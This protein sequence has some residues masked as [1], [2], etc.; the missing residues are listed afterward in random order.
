MSSSEQ[1]KNKF[2]STL[3]SDLKNSQAYGSLRKDTKEISDFYLTDEQREQLKSMKAGKRSF[4]HFGW[5]MRAMFY[6]LT[7]V[8]RLMFII[9]ILFLIQ[10]QGSFGEVNM[11]NINGNAIVGGALLVLVIL[12]EL[13]DKL[14][15]HDELE[16]GRKIQES[17]MPERMPNVNGWKLWLFTRS[18]NEVCG[19]LI[20]FLKIDEHRFSVAIADV[21]GK[22]L[23][24]ALITAK[25]QATIR[26]LAG[27]ITSLPQLIGRINTIVHRDSPAHMFS[28]LLYAECS[29]LNET[30]RFVN[31]GHFPALVVRNSEIEECVRGEAALGL[32]T[33]MN[34]SEHSA[35]LNTND[36]FVLYSD[37]LTEAKNELGE[38][39]GKEQL[40]NLLK[41]T[42]NESPEQTGFAILRTVDKFIG[43]TTPSDDLSI[44]ILQRT[45]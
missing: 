16:A 26:S 11:L 1:P 36:R 21:A 38:F 20:D 42:L 12:L 33:I 25:L 15:A 10:V 7:P 34:F 23:H 37:G 35:M 31:A 43:T 32:T 6:K 27:E 40:L 18:A 14:L 41:S 29:E 5:I 19:D 22:G 28:S 9:G 45:E 44:I 30:I 24:A 3:R 8:R 13:K 4:Y 39:F 2:F 17:L